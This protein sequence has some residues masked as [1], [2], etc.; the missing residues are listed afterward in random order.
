M[1]I[2]GFSHTA[3]ADSQRARVQAHSRIAFSP[4]FRSFLLFTI[5]AALYILPFMRLYLLGSD[6]GTLVYGAVRVFHGQVFTRDFFEVMGP[7]TLYLLAGF[8]KLF[9]V[10]FLTTRIWLFLCSLGTA[11]LIYL[12]SHRICRSYR[13]LPPIF[14]A[15]TCFGGLWP[16]I[17]HHGDSN[18]FAL[19]AVASL[20]LWYDKRYPF[21]L[22]MAGVLT[23]V[24]TVILQPKGV[25]L[26]A[27]SL[28]WLLIL[29]RREKISAS[30]LSL[31]GAGFLGVIGL[32]VLYF[33]AKGALG[34]LIYVNFIWPLSHYQ[35][36][37]S[38]P[39]AGDIVF[40]WS[41]WVVPS[42]K[43]W[44]VPLACVLI[45][46]LLVVAAF[47]LL[48][49]V[50]GARVR[51]GVGRPD[52]LLF[53]LCGAALWLAE[54]HR[55]D[56]I[57]LVY[58]SPLWMILCVYFL[59]EDKRTA[60]RNALQFLT[61]TSVFLASFNLALLMATRTVPTR[62][63]TV[64]TFGEIPVLSFLNQ[65]VSPGE[66]I[67]AYPYCPR[68]YFL[69]ATVNPTPYSILLYN[70]NTPEQFREVVRILDQHKVKYVVWD[71]DLENVAESVF[72]TS[73]Q[74]LLEGHIIEPYLE[75]HYKLVQ[76]IDGYRILERID[77]S[78]QQ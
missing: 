38:V 14:F 73:T 46:P 77:H 34:S 16:A 4:G 78:R 19:S 26:F 12:L 7:G 9:G 70:Y 67:F 63:G 24:T 48:L 30:T 1:M 13:A 6:E 75:S 39:Y 57:H 31:I 42:M 17:S 54:I 32:V 2:E 21:L 10:S 53:W 61:V 20:L 64:K 37:N 44:T 76:D 49:P 74:L 52:V 51:W 72:P 45:I 50:L 47:P 40:T 25:L 69:G 18:F 43:V 33:W 55:K 29:N 15:A 66:E 36:V 11:V 23:G 60:A 71:K 3:N 65:H 68:F 8:F 41:H 59:T 35:T 27:A 58:G 56:V 62:V 28:A 5:F 22:L